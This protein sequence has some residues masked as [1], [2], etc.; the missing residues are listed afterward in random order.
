MN[1][2]QKW[3]DIVLLVPGL[4]FLVMGCT[5]LGEDAFGAVLG[6]G[7]G[8]PMLGAFLWRRVCRRKGSFAQEGWVCIALFAAVLFFLMLV[9]G[10]LNNG[11][12]ALVIFSLVFGAGLTAAYVLRRREELQ[13][14]REAEAE[15]QSRAQMQNM[16]VRIER[17]QT[18]QVSAQTALT[19]CP[20]CGAPA[21]EKICPYCGMEKG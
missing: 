5:D 20:H 11:Q 7:M 17:P 19:I 18:Q 9:L 14:A 13:K 3:L 21:K 15:R 1:D 12:G 8:L 2:K 10:G 16:A 4:F 6:F